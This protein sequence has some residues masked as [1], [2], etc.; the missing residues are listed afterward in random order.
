MDPIIEF[1]NSNGMFAS[2]WS[3]T[4]SDARD[5]PI[6]RCENCT[7]CPEEIGGRDVKF[8]VCSG[9]K[10]KLDFVVHYCSRWGH[11]VVIFQCRFT[12][13]N[14][15]ITLR[16]ACQQQ[17]WPKHKKHCG[18][19]RVA[20]KLP[21][22]VHDQF[23]AFPQIPDHLRHVVPTS[24]GHH[25][26]LRSIGFPSPD[27]QQEHSPALQRQISLLNAD[28]EADYFLFDEGDHPVR[29]VLHATWLKTVFRILRS[30]ILSTSRKNGLE[31]IAEYLIKVMEQ[32]P[33][34]SRERILTQLEGEY[35]G[36]IRTKMREWD[37]RR[38]ENGLEGSS[39]LEYMSGNLTATMP[40]VM[41]AMS[42]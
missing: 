32:K 40:S 34:L 2:A 17:D 14:K 20:K 1:M 36:D 28:K 31:A 24:D 27:T 35:G 13:S 19:A 23:W 29:V 38:V 6:I 42:A 22:T 5:K 16:R 12:N 30:D 9:C 25:V 3:K 4:L 26:S 10:S 39:L 21:G 7:K 18:K 37:R 15:W 11:T 41:N 8:M 33:G